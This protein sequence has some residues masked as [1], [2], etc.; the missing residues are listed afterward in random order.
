MAGKGNGI[1][2]AAAASAV[3]VVHYLLVH[4]S[5]QALVTL[6]CSMAHGM[7]GQGRAGQGGAGQDASWE[8]VKGEVTFWWRLCTEQSLS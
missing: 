2:F 8:P 3:S 7:A 4:S 6:K 1:N 5:S